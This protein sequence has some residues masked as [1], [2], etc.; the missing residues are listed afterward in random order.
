[1]VVTSPAGGGEETQRPPAVP[2]GTWVPLK[3]QSSGG[4]QLHPLIL[5][6]LVCVPV[7][8]VGLVVEHKYLLTIMD[9]I[10]VTYPNN[11]KVSPL[12]G[13]SFQG[14]QKEGEGDSYVEI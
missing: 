12:N 4:A 10:T 5:L 6:L 3:S 8:D 14:D 9:A 11:N 1:M 2:S 7:E 13:I